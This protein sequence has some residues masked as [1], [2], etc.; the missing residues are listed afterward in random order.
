MSWDKTVVLGCSC[1]TVGL[2]LPL[3]QISI[4]LVAEVNTN[5]FSFSLRPES[6][7]SL[8]RITKVKV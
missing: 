5:V 3:K 7:V 4:V 6:K 8:I 1:D 2:L